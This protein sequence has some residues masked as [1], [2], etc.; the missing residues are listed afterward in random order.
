MGHG[1]KF[2]HDKTLHYSD[3]LL[4]GSVKVTFDSDHIQLSGH[5]AEATNHHRVKL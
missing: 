5:G 2:C 1:T 4:H 3:Q